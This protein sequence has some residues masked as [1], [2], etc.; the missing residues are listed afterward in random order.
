MVLEIRI[1]NFYSIKEEICLDFRA[2][3]LKS[4]QARSLEK[5]TFQVNKTDV[6]KTLVLYGANASGK[7]NIIKAIR[8]CH[9]LIL[10]SHNYNADTR[11]AFSPFK[12][13]GFDSQPSHYFIRFVRDDVEYEYSFSIT[14]QEVVT[15]S[16]HYYPKGRI[17]TIFLR[18]QRLGKDKRSIYTFGNEIKRPFDVAESTSNKTLYISRASQMDREIAKSIFNYFSDTF[19]LQYV[20]FGLS[21]IEQLSY[22]NK[23][24]LLQALK[25][26]DSDI[27]DVSIR[28]IKLPTTIINHNIDDLS[29]NI[30]QSLQDHLQITTY[31][32]QN[33]E[34][35]FDFL[36][37]E[38]QGTIKLFF[39]MLTI[40]EVVK[41]GKVLLVDEIEESLHTKLIEHIFSYL[42]TSKN[43]QLICTTHN[44]KLLNLKKLRKDQI[45]FVNKK[46]DS[47]SDV[48]SLTDFTDFRDTMDLE[49]AYLQGRFDA[50]P[51]IYEHHDSIK[52]FIHEEEK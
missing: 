39:I 36:T 19:I 38:S 41:H 37:E 44:T 12:F 43:A 29:V 27:S 4:A 48:Y 16:L 26:A 49:S 52:Q 3:N 13:D 28:K 22:K 10:Q 51:Y 20:N 9:S 46:S 25:Y 34:T 35:P 15:E 40:L 18:D 17:K 33:P 32:L 30:E 31:H 6:L 7:S 11:F 21:T 1:A 14:Q 42:N 5:N 45:Y 50:I 47:S 24:L 2:A 23:N 8:F